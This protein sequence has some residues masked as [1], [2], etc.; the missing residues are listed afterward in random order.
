[1]RDIWEAIVFTG[2]RAGE[3]VNLRLDCIGRLG[4]LPMFW[5]DQTKV[6]N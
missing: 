3:V 1:M 6:G 4:G 2:R 5:H